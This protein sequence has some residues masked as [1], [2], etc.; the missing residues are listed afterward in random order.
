MQR[1][2]L[3]CAFVFATAV[4]AGGK[5][6][7]AESGFDDLLKKVPESPNVLVVLN[8]E[9]IFA[10]QVAT[11]GGWKQQYE[12][13]YADS[14]LLLPPTA[15]QFVL[16]ADLDLAHFQPRWQ[17]AVMRLSSD[18]STAL[19]ARSI[20]GQRDALA[21]L[22]VVATPKGAMIVKFGPHIFGL[23]QPGDRQAVGRWIQEAKARDAAALSP[24]LQAAADVPERVGTEIIMALDL[25][26]ALGS[27]AS[28]PG[29]E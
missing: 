15:Q 9:K 7:S 21:G 13:T 22:D 5:A 11:E 1:W 26:D 17:A 24:Y 3:W 16:A 18:P 14:P 20:G 19:I 2:A 8:A 12:S 10:S 6:Q 29:H 25:T 23:R 27:G 4:F 28:P